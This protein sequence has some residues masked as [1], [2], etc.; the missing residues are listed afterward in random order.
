MFET[1]VVFCC[2]TIG[3]YIFTVC[4]IKLFL[5]YWKILNGDNKGKWRFFLFPFSPAAFCIL[6]L[7]SSLHIS[8]PTG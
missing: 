2:I 8:T 7:V 6:Q 4:T 1:S 5:N 3:V